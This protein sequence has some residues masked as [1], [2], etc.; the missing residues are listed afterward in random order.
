MLLKQFRWND[1][2]AF[3]EVHFYFRARNIGDNKDAIAV[4]SLF[5]P[6]DMTLLDQSYHTLW[7]SI[8]T[9]PVVAVNVKDLV[10]VVAMVP[11]HPS[12][13]GKP[14]HKRFF[15]VEKPGL[16]VANMGGVE[17]ELDNGDDE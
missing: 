11:H 2:L 10:S 3:G 9:D 7:S 12:I 13:P 8:K 16:D 5:G 15:V 17:D 1:E 4:I 6:P 14:V